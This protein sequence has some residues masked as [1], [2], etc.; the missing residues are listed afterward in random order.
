MKRASYIAITIIALSMGGYFGAYFL[1]ADYRD[2]G[3][4][5]PIYVLQYRIGSL[6]LQGLAPVFEPARRIDEN[7]FRHHKKILLE[8]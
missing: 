2:I 4:S 7:F 6:S 5:P 1:L 8:F 3:D